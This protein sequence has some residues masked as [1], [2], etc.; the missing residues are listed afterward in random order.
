MASMDRE[1]YITRQ[2]SYMRPWDLA[3]FPTAEALATMDEREFSPTSWAMWTR[4]AHQ[5]PND[6]SNAEPPT[7]G[8]PANTEYHSPT[9]VRHT[10]GTPANRGY[11]SPQPVRQSSGVSANPGHR[12]SQPARQSR[13]TMANPGY[14]SP[15]PVRPMSERQR[16]VY[17]FTANNRS[18][19]APRH[20]MNSSGPY[21][22]FGHINN[23][24]PQYVQGMP[25]IPPTFNTT[26]ER[27]RYAQQLMDA[28]NT[29]KKQVLEARKKTA[30]EL[31][32][33]QQE[34]DVYELTQDH[35]ENLRYIY[36]LQAQ[37]AEQQAAHDEYGRQWENL[38]DLVET[39]WSEMK[40]PGP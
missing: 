19:A 22:H 31:K 5:S 24:P 14:H 3:S 34:I 20:M 11:Y 23:R 2:L 25:Y 6:R 32:R 39:L 18:N 15:Q 10:R 9:P 7:R 12:R 29:D 30:A 16:Q 35:Q 13:V 1:E 36:P 27:Q 40:V 38:G 4:H 33:L 28:L 21:S 37:L 26:E 17:D 8:T